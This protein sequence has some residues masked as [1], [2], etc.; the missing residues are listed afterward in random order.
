[1]HFSKNQQGEKMQSHPFRYFLTG[2]DGVSSIEYALIGSLIAVVI[3]ISVGLVGT[4]TSA[5]FGLVADCV[6]F[7]VSGAGVCP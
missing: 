3:V 2:E 5:L 4:S 7:A 6:S 1:V